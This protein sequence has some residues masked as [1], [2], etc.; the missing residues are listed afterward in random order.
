M[1][2]QFSHDSSSSLGLI[3]RNLIREICLLDPIEGVCLCE[4]DETSPP[5]P[6]GEAIIGYVTSH[7]PVGLCVSRRRDLD[8]CS[9]IIAPSRWMAYHLRMNGCRHVEM[10]PTGRNS[11]TRH[12]APRTPD[13]RFIV[14]SG[15][16]FSYRGGHDLVISAMRTF[17]GRH[18]DCWLALQWGYDTAGCASF[19]WCGEFGRAVDGMTDL[20]S[21]LT[22][23]G[24]DGRRL[25]MLPPDKGPQAQRD[26]YV[27]SD[28][29]LFVSRCEFDGNF[30]LNEY[31]SC[32]RPAV[33][34][35]RTGQADNAMH[36]GLYG[37]E[38]YIPVLAPEMATCWFEATVDGIFRQ[39]EL[40]YG[41]ITGE[42]WQ[43]VPE[44]DMGEAIAWSEVA[45]R[46]HAIAR[47]CQPRERK[48]IS[49]LTRNLR[50]VAL[51]E[52]DQHLLA[53]EEFR[54]SLQIDPQ[55]AETYNCLGNALDSQGHHEDALPCFDKA[56]ELDSA[57]TVAWFNKG[58]T[59]KRLDRLEAAVECYLRAVASTPGFVMGWLN[60]AIACSANGDDGLAEGYYKRAIHL[61]SEQ[62]D[63]LHLLGDLYCK[64]NRFDEALNCYHRAI[65]AAPDQFLTYNAM[66]VL[67][68]TIGNTQ[69][70]LECL[71]RAIRIKPDMI[72]ALTNI[73][74][75]Y[76][77]MQMPDESVR[78]LKRAISLDPDD[79][80]AHWNLALAMLSKELSHEAWQEYEWRFRKTEPVQ[81]RHA[82]LPRWAG[83]PLEGRNILLYTEQGYGDSVQFARYISLV[84][85]RQA[86]V[87]IECQDENIRSIMAQ[88]PGVAKTLL[89]T[90]EKL[91][92]DY[93]CPLLSLPL[94]FDTVLE[95]IPG[96]N[97]YITPDEQKME[98]WHGI[99]GRL[100]RHTLK[101]G[102]SW[103][104]RKT[105]R[106]E[107]RSLHILQLLKI[108]LIPGVDFFSLQ[109]GED[110]SQLLELPADITVHNVAEHIVDFA[111]SA[112]ALSCM[113]LL[114]SI[115]TSLA[116]LGG[117]LGVP[118]WIML[119]YSADWRWMFGRVDS[120]WYS[121]VRLIRQPQPG[122]WENVVEDIFRELKNKINS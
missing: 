86:T 98:K 81:E 87:T 38:E 50:G 56:L 72:P 34:S 35:L 5:L 94:V 75:A 11:G 7:D 65:A 101:V 18:Q 51:L 82:Y 12:P 111:D 47:Q 109:V 3:G 71:A 19:G 79:A 43:R 60:L 23:Q 53:E 104:G 28:V 99:I 9:A 105:K 117:A 1:R 25:I 2:I 42:A 91:R 85:Q 32:G 24:I 78:F 66:G 4:I 70:A 61:D 29:G 22:M 62:S 20:V 37:V 6:E 110:Q 93:C 118:T 14:Y 80:D 73:G 103:S 10:L 64:Q 107:D 33:I 90:D 95:T 92:Y 122:N 74:T 116:H 88:A 83:E 44:N 68:L 63:A 108:L 69:A 52:S 113:D 13:G 100:S 27:A 45:T 39:L 46:I 58:N 102:L 106:N 114:I 49:S 112:A 26:V 76:R 119:K 55:N 48:L 115:D 41:K 31:L 67:F 30:A 120:P 59:L 8:R 16:H 121:S 57:F 36:H 15:G 84:A 97:G 77:E 17:M 96:V 40:A 54:Q 21:F 89:R